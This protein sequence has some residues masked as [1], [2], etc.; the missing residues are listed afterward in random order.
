VASTRPHGVRVAVLFE[1]HLSVGDLDRSTAFYREVVGLPVAFEAPDRS[2]TFL[3]VGAPRAGMLGLWAVGSAPVGLRLHLAFTSSLQDV[4]DACGRLRASG[5]TPLSFAA[6]ETDE[7]SV[8]AWLPGA[9]VYFRD[10]DGH[11]LEYLAVL[12]EPGDPSGGVVPWSQ[13]RAAGGRAP[14]A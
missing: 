3:W 14:G 1:A 9:A 10:P 11:L 4:L 12:D 6:T 2:A 8:I 5:V 7:P 13:W